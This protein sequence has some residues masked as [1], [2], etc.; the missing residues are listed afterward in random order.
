[1]AKRSFWSRVFRRKRV[2][3]EDN[4]ELSRRRTR[5]R[6]KSE[7]E[8]AAAEFFDEAMS[9]DDAGPDEPWYRQSG[10]LFPEAFPDA[11]PVVP[12]AD[13]SDAPS[14]PST[15]D[16]WA[17]SPADSPMADDEERPQPGL[18]WQPA[19]GAEPPLISFESDV[20]LIPRAEPPA[21]S[22]GDHDDPDSVEESDEAGDAGIEL[23][24]SFEEP[25][26]ASEESAQ[27]GQTEATEDGHLAD[28][29]PA[30]VHW[31]AEDAEDSFAAEE[32]SWTAEADVERDEA[33][34][35][36]EAAAGDDIDD[37]EVSSTVLDES[38]ADADDIEVS[39]AAQ[40]EGVAD[41]E[42]T[43]A[44]LDEDV[45]DSEV[46]PAALDE[47]VADLGVTPAALE[48]DPDEQRPE[49]VAV[50]EEARSDG[51]AAEAEVTEP[52]PDIDAPSRDVVAVGE[53]TPAAPTTGPPSVIPIRGYYLTRSHDTLRS[54][55]AQFLNA[56]ERWAQL[57]SI[58]A[59]MPGVAESGPD[60]LLAE[61]TAIALPGE[62]LA[63]GSPDPVY[64]WTL[65]ETFLYTAW[66]REPTPEEVVPF[67]RGLAAG[68]APESREIGAEL[69]G[70]ESPVDLP[71][72][73]EM[74]PITAPEQQHVASDDAP[75]PSDEPDIDEPVVDAAEVDEPDLVEADLAEPDIDEP[76]VDEPDIDEPVVDAVE[77]DEPD[78]VE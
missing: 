5:R 21:S 19:E 8:I 52:P 78:L 74:P 48:D 11:P 28:A 18:A 36:T 9:G 67:W 7:R 32:D 10:P 12:A 3:A 45:A 54:V 24:E 31:G 55:A 75:T 13:T 77:V 42:V 26:D 70:I 4:Q 59:A 47:D 69:P 56:P 25:W 49:A 62:P 16:L 51:A 6:A 60:E 72:A 40:D 57:R 17:P 37:I 2:T 68:G 71:P 65:A 14:V 50:D 53:T 46:T 33:A 1:M 15:D 41:L 22:P 20:P 76:V 44:A 35:P 27:I 29:E 23:S 66:G 61:G 63:W 39:S 38:V 58:N 34:E 30:G 43:P 73:F 64:L